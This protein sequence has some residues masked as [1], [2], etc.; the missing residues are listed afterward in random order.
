VDIKEARSA[1][2]HA[3]LAPQVAA[4]EWWA[5][6][7]D[8]RPIGP[9]R[10]PQL[11]YLCRGRGE[12]ALEAMV[13]FGDTQPATLHWH[14]FQHT[15]LVSAWE[16]CQTSANALPAAQKRAA[17]ASD[18]AEGIAKQLA[19]VEAAHLTAQLDAAKWAGMDEETGTLGVAHSLTDIQTFIANGTLKATKE[20]YCVEGC[21]IPKPAEAVVQERANA[22]AA[23]QKLGQQAAGGA[24]V[25][26]PSR[27]DP[28]VVTADVACW[29]WMDSTDE[30]QG[31]FS[32]KDMKAWLRSGY[33]KD[34]NWVVHVDDHS[35]EWM[36][37]DVM[38]AQRSYP[39]AWLN[40]PGA[41]QVANLSA[42]IR[43]QLCEA[44]QK[45][46]RRLVLSTLDA[47]VTAW[48]ASPAA[49]ESALA[50]R[51]QPP[52]AVPKAIP[53][54]R[55]PPKP[56]FPS[57]YLSAGP[58]NL[59]HGAHA[60]NSNHF[61]DAAT[62]AAA[63]PAG[64]KMGGEF[65]AVPGLDSP[66]HEATRESEKTRAATLSPTQSADSGSPEPA[67][68][69]FRAPP[70]HVAPCDVVLQKPEDSLPSLKGAKSHFSHDMPESLGASHV[71]GLMD[72]DHAQQCSRKQPE[73]CAAADAPLAS[74]GNHQK[75]AF[76]LDEL[77]LDPLYQGDPATT[78]NVAEATHDDLAGLQGGLPEGDLQPSTG[79]PDVLA[80]D[81]GEAGSSVGHHTGS[82][83][84]DD[85]CRQ[86]LVGCPGGSGEAAPIAVD[87]RPASS[88]VAMAALQ[89]ASSPRLAELLGY[90]SQEGVPSFPAEC[91]RPRKHLM[92]PQ[93]KLTTRMGR[94]RSNSPASA[95]GPNS[96]R[97][98]GSPLANGASC[99]HSPGNFSGTDS[100]LD[101]AAQVAA[102]SIQPSRTWLEAVPPEEPKA[103]RV[104]M[105]GPERASRHSVREAVR[106]EGSADT[107][108]WKHLKGRTKDLKFGRSQ[109]HAWGL[110]AMERI[111]PGDFVIEYVGQ[112][113]RLKLSD[114]REAEYEASGLGSSYLFRIDHEW[115]VD[116][117]K[118]G[119]FARF[120][121]HSCDPNCHTKI[122]SVDGVK[123]IAI[124]AKR[125]IEPNEE[126]FYDYKFEREPDKDAVPC[127]CG[128]RNCRRRLN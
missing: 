48:K 64:G 2:A 77:E 52:K 50:P 97:H 51:L 35:Q 109:V 7:A 19:A 42:R 93:P 40:D 101:A 27:K 124:Y 103:L 22:L 36:L 5:W 73:P 29:G 8:G 32:M 115:V 26:V 76:T 70:S 125:V 126:L 57:G 54:P 55:P 114:A 61:I 46:L 39:E 82:I 72:T 81:S 83:A 38:S 99:A 84:P 100:D 31:P 17:A 47:Q 21:G 45:E 34:T 120:I 122:I 69:A 107:S 68:P 53:S 59:P 18:K 98:A 118:K 65:T 23:A 10:L 89:H 95:K 116:A 16:R 87:R 112:L 71:P 108:R 37:K 106:D 113:I 30:M 111:E 88:R 15:D 66:T 119:G 67:V 90:P 20:L 63:V 56:P 91:R 78:A 102:H 79:S 43:D 41:P 33:L 4:P 44:M 74:V 85:A 105:S 86:L 121:N 12:L 128:A 49:R 9:V 13:S 58:N 25:A 123:H 60:T 28:P 24:R 62:A 104:G 75:S 127:S 80:Q 117:T 6:H 96:P 1:Y 11:L 3:C 110:F 92:S 14:L 94:P